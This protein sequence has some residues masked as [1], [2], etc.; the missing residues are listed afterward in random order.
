MADRDLTENVSRITR[1]L[2]RPGARREIVLPML[3]IPKSRHGA[4]H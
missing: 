3:W 2:C 4:L 1:T